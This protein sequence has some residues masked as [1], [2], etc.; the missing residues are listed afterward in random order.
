V[1]AARVDASDV[2]AAR[3]A[4]IV[5]IAGLVALIVL[6]VTAGTMLVL[7]FTLL[8][9]LMRLRDSMRSAAHAPERATDYA[10]ASVRS[11]ELGEMIATHNVM[12]SKVADSIRRDRENAE[13]R[14]H[15]LTRNDPL[16]GMANRRAFLENLASRRA[17]DAEAQGG[18]KVCLVN[19]VQLR[20]VNAALGQQAGDRLLKEVGGRLLRCAGPGS[21]AAHL[22]AGRF[23]V[24]RRTGDPRFDAAGLAERLIRDAAGQYGIGN[25]ALSVE[26]R[27]GITHAPYGGGP[28]AEDLLNQAELALERTGESSPYAFY[29][30]AMAQAAHDRQALARGLER[31]LSRQD[32]IFIVYQAKASLVEPVP[33]L[34]GAE[35]LVRWRHPERGLVGPNVFVPIAESTGL[36]LPLGERVLRTACAQIRTWLDRRGRSPRVA[37]NLSAHQFKAAGLVDLIQRV[38]RESAVPA[39]LLDLEITESAAMRDVED[40]A[41]IVQ[42]LRALGVRVSL[43][44]FGT[45]H[46]SLNYL[47]RLAV[48]TIKID[49]SFV[50][51]I[52]RDP[53]ADAICAAILGMAHALGRTVVAEGVETESQ[54]DFLRKRGCGQIQGYLFARPLPADEFEQRFLMDQTEGVWRETGTRAP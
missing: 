2:P 29:E 6:F 38:L 46:S 16:T 1:F 48:D 4:Y 11:D 19:L 33:A 21:F 25:D 32:E 54:C 9:P 20:R 37:V 50:D 31:A 43:D 41:R 8:R 18:I 30:E 7:H 12:L 10:I 45:G 40:A 13:A 39:E 34:A 49:K 47:R 23:A 52:G 35:A 53:N 17:G 24:A 3:N 15:Y 44:D 14:E 28:S 26:L 36:I 5:R 27:V 42:A 22:G 51:D